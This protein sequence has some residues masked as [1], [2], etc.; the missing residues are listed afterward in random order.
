M[1]KNRFIGYAEP[2]KKMLSDG[3]DY[4]LLKPRLGYGEA[5][6]VENASLT[7]MRGKVGVNLA[8]G[9]D[10]E[11]GLDMTK[12]IIEKILTWVVDWSFMDEKDKSVKFNKSAVLNLDP[13]TGAEISDIIDAHIEEMEN[14]K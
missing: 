12:F 9:D 11:F 5:I 6:H 8:E 2:I 14:L 3:E 10:A 7:G 13:K 4:I 1:S